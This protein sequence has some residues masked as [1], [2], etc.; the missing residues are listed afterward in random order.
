MAKGPSYICNTC[1]K[2][3]EFAAKHEDNDRI[4]T[5]VVKKE[6]AD[7]TLVEARCGMRYKRMR[8]NETPQDITNPRRHRRIAKT[9]GS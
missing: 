2:R 8:V 9:T 3:I 7:G 6:E 5:V 1:N 4:C